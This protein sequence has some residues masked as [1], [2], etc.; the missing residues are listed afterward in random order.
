MQGNPRDLG[1]VQT[2][3][4][5]MFNSVRQDRTQELYRHFTT[6]TDTKNIKVVFNIVK[7]TILTRHIQDIINL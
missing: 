2:F 6:A 1:D 7:D 5:Q 4:V 3:L